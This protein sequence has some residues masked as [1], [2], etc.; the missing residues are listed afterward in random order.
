MSSVIADWR[1]LFPSFIPSSQVEAA[2]ADLAAARADLDAAIKRA[3]SAARAAAAAAARADA[4]EVASRR[5]L[6]KAEETA[7][8]ERRVAEEEVSTCTFLAEF[9]WSSSGSGSRVPGNFRSTGIPW[10][11]LRS[12]TDVLKD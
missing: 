5:S 2:K 8:A 12:L 6:A 1:W 11:S 3:N 9:M 10:G 7:E 4:A